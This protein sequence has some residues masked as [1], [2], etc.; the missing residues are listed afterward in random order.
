MSTRENHVLCSI[1]LCLSHKHNVPALAVSSGH[2]SAVLCLVTWGIVAG[3]V[4][5]WD[6]L[7]VTQDLYCALQFYEN[8]IQWSPILIR[9][10]VLWCEFC[11]EGNNALPFWKEVLH[12]SV[13]III[14]KF[15][16]G[17]KKP[18]IYHVPKCWNNVFLNVFSFTFQT[19]SSFKLGSLSR[20]D[21]ILQW[22]SLSS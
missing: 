2:T 3:V 14:Q 16:K 18:L 19:F 13:S 15:L 22:S 6:T 1:F 17:T 7:I 20:E 5:L 8:I 9:E 21:W 10:C 11:S 4:E 12:V